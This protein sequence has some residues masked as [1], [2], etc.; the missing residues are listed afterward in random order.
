MNLGYLSLVSLVS[1][2]TVQLTPIWYSP[3]A[4]AANPAPW[5][6]PMFQIAMEKVLLPPRRGGAGEADIVMVNN[7]SK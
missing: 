5:P 1:V 7:Q 4:A 3:L 6:L 2:K